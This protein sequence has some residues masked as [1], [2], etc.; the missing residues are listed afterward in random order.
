[1]ALN[2]VS[3]TLGQGG[4]GRQLP[5]TDY[6]SGLLFY[7]NTL[8]SG[9]SSS[10]RVKQFFSPADALAAGIKN[11]YSDETKATA[12]FTVTSI[13]STNDSV[14]LTV[15]EPA[16]KIVTLGSYVKP[17]TD[18]T[19][20]LVATGIANAMNAG[21]YIHGYVATSALAVVTITARPGLGVFLNTGTP[22][23]ATYSQGATL[24]GTLSQFTGGVASFQAVMYYHIS[25]FFRI[26]GNTSLFVGIYPVPGS[27]TFSEITT[28][29]NFANGQIKQ[30]GVYKDL[31]AAF[32]SGDI[33]LIH[34]VCAQN[35]SNHKELIA[36][37]AADI[38]A[39]SDIST[40]P[41]LSQLT[42]NYCSAIIA[43]DGGAQGANLF[44][45]TGK[46]ITTLGATLGAVAKASVAQSIAWVAN[47][48]ISDGTECS[49]IAFANGVLFSNASVTDSL[50]TQLQNYRYIFLRKFV[51]VAGSYFNEA[52]T[53]ITLASD[54]A[55]IPDNRTMQKATRGIYA[56]VIPAL[57][58]PITLNA[59]GTLSNE[60]IA[61]FTGL[62]EAPLIQMV[63]NG[64]LSGFN[65]S[66]SPSQ[67]ILQTGIL[68]INVSLVQI[69][70][71]R[72]ININIGYKVSV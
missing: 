36:I 24:A 59:D 21:S 34:N 47:F 60:A 15:T 67:N 10:N 63:R 64:E 72:N 48:N 22:L 29:Q 46:S 23:A 9:F 28:M 5:G 65:V 16:G 20:A 6:I 45:A 7:S 1:M 8:P 50:L 30:I 55:Y 52:S 68:T 27:Y 54:Y 14:T 71:G 26:S 51:G 49:V 18:T 4:S 41:N 70:T 69:A 25:E 61:Y 2:N 38:S 39:I 42:A 13:G 44:Y 66:I 58:S 43:Q 3:F 31:S 53:S 11:D 33:T 56:S 62:A 17:S 19:T 37:Y 35:V 40:L 57:N 32:S 12:T